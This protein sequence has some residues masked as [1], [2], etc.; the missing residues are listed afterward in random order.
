MRPDG[1]LLLALFWS[2]IIAVVVYCFYRVFTK[3]NDR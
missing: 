1:W 3:E 2:A